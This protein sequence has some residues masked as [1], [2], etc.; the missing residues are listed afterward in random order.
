MLLGNK[1]G[2]DLTGFYKIYILKNKI[3]VV[4]EIKEN[5]LVIRV[6]IFNL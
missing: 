6:I 3:R 1:A 5:I 2:M 4:Y